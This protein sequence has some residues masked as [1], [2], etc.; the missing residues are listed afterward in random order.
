MFMTVDVQFT[1]I[2][3]D[4]YTAELDFEFMSIFVQIYQK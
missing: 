3:L 2:L 1:F 4:K